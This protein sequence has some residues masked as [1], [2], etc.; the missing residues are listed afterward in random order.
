MDIYLVSSKLVSYLLVVV[1]PVLGGLMLMLLS[2]IHY[3][4][5]FF[6]GIY[7]GDPVFYQHVFWIFGHPEVY[8]LILPGFGI[9]STIL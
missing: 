8:I 2:D 7:G 5:V 9:L 6:D 3:N 4:S 1:L